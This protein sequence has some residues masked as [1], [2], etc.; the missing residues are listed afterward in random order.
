MK[1][2]LKVLVPSIIAL[3]VASAAHAG[4]TFDTPQG[5]L[6]IGGD[7]E[8]NVNAA[9]LN[10][11]VTSD[12][13]TDGYGTDTRNNDGRIVVSFTGERA[14]SNGN[15]AG[16][17]VSP[18]WKPNGDNGVDDAWIALGVKNDWMLKV[19]RYE[20]YDLTPAGQDT[21]AGGYEMYKA[22]EARGRGAGNKASQM[23]INK[24]YDQFYFELS[25][26]YGDYGSA[27]TTNVNTLPSD[28]SLYLNSSAIAHKMKDPVM[29]R[30]VVA[31]TGDF[32]TL[33]L[34][35]EFNVITDA[36]QTD[37]GVDLSKRNGV[38]G[39][40]TFKVNDDTS[41][42]LRGAYL[43]AVANNQ[44][45][46]GAGVQYQNLWV[47]YL[48][49]NEKIKNNTDLGTTAM[50]ADAHEVYASYKFPSVMGI[51]NFDMYLGTYWTQLLAKD[52]ASTSLA[53][54]TDYGSRV[55]FKYYF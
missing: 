13:S 1:T 40:A 10:K 12:G 28:D 23:L 33:A 16:F 21:W 35:G 25:S 7:V 49:G 47:A 45:S 27:N 30:P 38:G 32:V 39:N 46:L 19:G 44:Y 52:D 55:R 37:N 5:K 17:N 2:T 41:I 11:S 50:K 24:Q 43:D 26:L 42:V 51:S 6:S 3:C 18:L 34:G 29:L 53:K 14:L 15:F 8:Y 22:S 31:W 54:P 36:Y 9:H 20:A 4:A 48:F